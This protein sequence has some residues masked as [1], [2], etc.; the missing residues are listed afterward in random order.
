M[1]M[2]KWNFCRSFSHF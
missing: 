2:S 1:F